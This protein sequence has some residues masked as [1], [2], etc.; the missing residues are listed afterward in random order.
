M[1]N[2][3]DTTELERLIL[4]SIDQ[5]YEVHAQKDLADYIFSNYLFQSFPPAFVDFSYQYR[6]AIA[7][8]LSDERCLASLIEYCIHSTKAYTYQ[9]NQFINFTQGYDELLYSEYYD[10]FS[11]LRAALEQAETPEALTKAY[12]M[13]LKTHHERL[14]LILSSYCITYV[15][16]ELPDNPLLRTVPCEEYS[17]QFQLRLLNLAIT[18]LRPPI[19]DI[20]C[21]VSGQLSNHLR[22]KGY[23]AFGVDR[24]APSTSNFFQQDWFEFDYGTD[25]WGTILAHQSFSTHFIHAHLH[26]SR[27][28]DDFARLYMRILGSLRIGGEFCYSPGLPFIEGHLEKMVGYSMAKTRIETNNMLGLG[29]IFYSVRVKR[30]A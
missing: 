26:H 25:K 16:T 12:A 13:A 23:P 28:A 7:D 27:S 17:A 2:H 10:F 15:S 4:N 20:G 11:Q 14:R 5:R 3:L 18:E 8:Y 22:S 24:L 30:G 6:Q 9:R 21:G 19:L 29:E 1:S